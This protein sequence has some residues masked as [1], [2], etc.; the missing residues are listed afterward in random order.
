MWIRAATQ[1]PFF[2]RFLVE[3]LENDDIYI[4]VED[5]FFAVA[6]SFTQHLHYAEYLSKTKEA[7]AMNA[8]TTA[9]IQRPTDGRAAQPSAELQRREKIEALRLGQKRGLDASIDEQFPA[10]EDEDLWAGTSLHG[11]MASPRKARPLI[12]LQGIRSTTRAAAGFSQSPNLAQTD[13]GCRNV[14]NGGAAV[15]PR[16]ETKTD[17]DDDLDVMLSTNSDVRT[18]QGE[19]VQRTLAPSEIAKK[20]TASR[21]WIKAGES[22]GSIKSVSATTKSSARTTG[23]S[24]I[25]RLIDELDQATEPTEPIKTETSER[26][27]NGKNQQKN[28][29]HATPKSK[30]TRLNDVPMFLI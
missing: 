8:E 18:S 14:I 28:A 16:N 24:R 15:R 22:D 21:G 11:L 6:Q 3:G 9:R 30:M 10:A 23:Q 26:R 17:S 4:M 13:G 19:A 12:G 27:D 5:E 25:K 20:D 7:K 2:F 29:Q 1:T